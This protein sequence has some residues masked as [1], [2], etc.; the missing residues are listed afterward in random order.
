M[1]EVHIEEISKLDRR[2][3]PI[4]TLLLLLF[5]IPHLT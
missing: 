2:L 3:L 5:R 1:I 4:T